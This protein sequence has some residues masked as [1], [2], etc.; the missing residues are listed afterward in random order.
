MEFRIKQLRRE[1]GMSQTE[2]A[3][4]A[5]VSRQTIIL[6]ESGVAKNTTTRT[7]AGIADALDTTADALFYDQSV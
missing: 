2:L 6:L 1:R 5:G 3:R 4:R 7:I